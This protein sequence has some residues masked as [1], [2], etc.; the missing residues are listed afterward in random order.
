M[1]P[2]LLGCRERQRVDLVRRRPPTNE[3]LPAFLRLHPDVEV[4]VN[5]HHHCPNR[6][7]S[8]KQ[9]DPHAVAKQE[10]PEE[11]LY[12]VPRRLDVVDVIVQSLPHCIDVCVDHKE[13]IQQERYE[14][15]DDDLDAEGTDSEE[16]RTQVMHTPQVIQEDTREDQQD[17]A[18]GE[19]TSVLTFRRVSR[20]AQ[21]QQERVDHSVYET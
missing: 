12:R 11:E 7:S 18:G 19:Y 15:F 5:T 21:V 4:R 17:E 10:Y 20:R 9:H 13:E 1:A 2:K 6:P 14:D 16:P 8:L 3:D